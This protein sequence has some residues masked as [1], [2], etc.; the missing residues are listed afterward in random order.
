MTGTRSPIST[1]AFPKGC[2]RRRLVRLVRHS[3]NGT[4]ECPATLV[5][6]GGYFGP[7]LPDGTVADLVT[8][9][10]PNGVA[11]ATRPSSVL[12]LVERAF[13]EPEVCRILAEAEIANIASIVYSSAS[14]FEEWGPDARLTMTGFMQSRLVTR[15]EEDRVEKKPLDVG[16]IAR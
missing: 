9:S 11:M 15:P 6:G 10:C 4:S 12:A 5:A 2:V 8:R 16:V 1:S 7:P 3:P 13:D 14:A